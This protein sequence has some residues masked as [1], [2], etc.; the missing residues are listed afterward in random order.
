MKIRNGFVSNSSSSSFIVAF[1]KTPESISELNEMLFGDSTSFPDP[2]GDK[3]YPS[4][5]VSE[6]VFNDM[7]EGEI[8]EERAIEIISQG[9][10]EGRPDFPFSELRS[11]YMDAEGNREKI[12]KKWDRE[13][14]E[15][16]KAAKNLFINFS[17]KLKNEKFFYFNYGDNEGDFY[18]AMEHG[19]LFYRL[20]HIK[21]SNH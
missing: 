13:N 18:C 1:E 5:E 11:L 9:Y 10:F 15:T 7:K 16:K 12:K 8:S 14:N 21:V 19:D 20:P 17:K 6:V 3:K 4:L 2:Y